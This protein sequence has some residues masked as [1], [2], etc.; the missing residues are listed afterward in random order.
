[1]KYLIIISLVFLTSCEEKKKCREDNKTEV[2]ELFIK[3]LNIASPAK[4]SQNG[5]LEDWDT[6]D[7][8]FII[9][10]C[11]NSSRDIYC[12]DGV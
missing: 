11:K 3:C 5:E 9:F 1:M 2:A 10:A 8:R 12:P 6:D 4:T 7:I